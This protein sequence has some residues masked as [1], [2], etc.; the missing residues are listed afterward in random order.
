MV[1]AEAISVEATLGRHSFGGKIGGGDIDVTQFGVNGKW[2]FAQPGFKPFLTAGVGGYA[3]DP[4]ATRFGANLGAG[5]QVDLTPLWSLE[6][7]YTLHQVTRNSPNSSYST[8]TLGLR[9]AF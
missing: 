1:I 5:V 3:F 7:R 2:Y 8:L 9:Y 4:G 6:G